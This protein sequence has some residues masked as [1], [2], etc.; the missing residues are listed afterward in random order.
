MADRQQCLAIRSPRIRNWSP[1]PGGVFAT[2][3]VGVRH[4]FVE[5]SQ[6]VRFLYVTYSHYKSMVFDVQKYGF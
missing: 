5:C 1:T 4:A 6:R 2:N 3:F